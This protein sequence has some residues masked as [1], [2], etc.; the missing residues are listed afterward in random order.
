MTNQ[1]ANSKK[2]CAKSASLPNGSDLSPG[3]DS[4]GRAA[5]PGSD[6]DWAECKEGNQ[7]RCVE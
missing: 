1:K 7:I 5:R 4:D 6:F 3:W 2:S